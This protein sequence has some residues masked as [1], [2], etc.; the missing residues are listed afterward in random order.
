MDLFK[1]LKNHAGDFSWPLKDPYLIENGHSIYL[2]NR[3]KGLIDVKHQEE[4]INSE[5][6]KYQKRFAFGGYAEDRELYLDTDLFG[7][8]LNRSI[9]LGIDI[10]CPTGTPVFLPLTGKIHSFQDN[11]KNGDYGP[12]IITSHSIQKESFF[13]LF[14]HLSRKSMVNLS[15]GKRYLKGEKLAELGD[16][17]ENG[18]WLPH[19][20]FQIIKDI[21]NYSGDYPGVAS[22]SDMKYF[23]I[24]CP[25]PK[26]IFNY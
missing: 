23:R 13:F 20:H 11:N 17:N 21:G 14:G 10:W 9:H 1:L 16:F 26:I 5:V 18:N 24:N 2:G 6:N 12:T 8:N 25:D 22:K 19:L 3:V 4:F 7:A 15:L